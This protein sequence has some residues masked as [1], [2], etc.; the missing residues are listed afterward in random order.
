MV[1]GLG[2][3]DL[4]CISLPFEYGGKVAERLHARVTHRQTVATDDAWKG[5]RAQVDS[6]NV[7]N[8]L[9][10]TRFH[11][12]HTYTRAKRDSRRTATTMETTFGESR[13]DR[14]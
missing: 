14:K 11:I 6:F 12:T 1:T 5:G 2:E 8:Q 13:N 3:A 10:N 4:E 9:S 7:D